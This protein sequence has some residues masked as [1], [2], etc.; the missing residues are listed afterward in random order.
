MRRK[1][2]TRVWILLAAAVL[3]ATASLL[4]AQ[5]RVDTGGR[6]LDANTRVG[7]GGYNSARDSTAG[8]NGNLVVTG[9]VTGGREFRDVVGYTDP[10]AFRGE[11]ASSGSDRFVRSS[12]GPSGYNAQV[13]RPFFGDSRG[14]APPPGFMPLGS[15]GGYVPA[16]PPRR[17]GSDLRLGSVFDTPQF[18]LPKPGELLLSGPVDPSNNNILIAA[19]PLYGVR[20]LNS[21]D[22]SDVIFLRRYTD[23][24]GDR[25]VGRSDSD[26]IRRMQ[27]E[28]R[29]T[30]TGQTEN[31]DALNNPTMD[32]PLDNT[33]PGNDPL[34]NDP[35][36]GQQA[37]Q[38]L[39]LSSAVKQSTQY[40]A[41]VDRL[42]KYNQQMKLDPAT[43]ANR[44]YNAQVRLAREAEE[45]KNKS[46]EPQLPPTRDG[47]TGGPSAPG[48][49]AL[50]GTPALPGG[51][52][53]PGTGA[54]GEP[55]QPGNLL[56][57]T[58][59]TERSKPPVISSL[60]TGVQAKGLADLLTEAETLMRD[61]KFVAA[62]EKYDLAAQ[63]APNNPMPLFGRANAELGA[64]FYAR[65]ETH[66]RQA[67][68]GAPA[69]MMAQYDL[70]KFLG[71]ER[72]EFLVR[73]LKEIANTEKDSARPLLLLAYIAYNEGNERMAAGYLDLAE[74]RSGGDPF[75]KTVRDHWQLAPYEG[76]SIDLNK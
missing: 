42:E 46:T 55:G 43:A 47:M 37:G 30:D 21:G 3:P 51:P 39:V 65:A 61:Q 59:I 24:T 73:D 36:T 12:A 16:P 45:Q 11:L 7:S 70:R 27:E 10:R 71:D 57:P 54:P 48:G 5:A 63:V 64:S 53:L 68:T 40:K 60:A 49:T 56:G 62:I 50:P 75:Y 19:S 66:L 41:L 44:E 76:S 29:D 23:A 8:L 9:N 25:S 1:N 6:V 33:I 31:S 17:Q 18:A 72:L 4:H 34:G 22:M 14:V 26:T 13:V 67:F 52:N 28:L 35:T 2:N 69:L 38:R 32:K 15:T 58:R 74:K 20:P